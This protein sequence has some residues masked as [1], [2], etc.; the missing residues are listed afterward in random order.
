MVWMRQYERE[1]GDA[2]PE[3]VKTYLDEQMVLVQKVNEDIKNALNK[4]DSL[5]KD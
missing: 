2:T 4:A 5:L 1:D 3:E